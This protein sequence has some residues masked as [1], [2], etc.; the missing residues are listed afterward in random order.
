M[1]VVQKIQIIAPSIT[2]FHASNAVLLGAPDWQLERNRRRLDEEDLRLPAV[3]LQT[4]TAL[5]A[6]RLVSIEEL[7]QSAQVAI[8]LALCTLLQRPGSSHLRQLDSRHAAVHSQRHFDGVDMA[9]SKHSQS[10]TAESE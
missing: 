2:H 6:R 3:G 10:E 5:C 8:H 9:A 4:K 1:E 7:F